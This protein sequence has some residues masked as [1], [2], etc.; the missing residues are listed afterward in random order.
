MLFDLAGCQGRVL[1]DYTISYTFWNIQQCQSRLVRVSDISRIKLEQHNIGQIHFGL[2]INKVT[3]L[4]ILCHNAILRPNI[5]I[6]GF[7]GIE[8]YTILKM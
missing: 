3:Y 1:L 6:A 7:S 2:D 8:K 4:F 5:Y